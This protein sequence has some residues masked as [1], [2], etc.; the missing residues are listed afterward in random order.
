MGNWRW[1]CDEVVGRTE[2]PVIERRRC[3]RCRI[4]RPLE[5]FIRA[6]DGKAMGECIQCRQQ[7]PDFG[8]RKCAGVPPMGNR[9]RYE[10]STKTSNYR[11]EECWKK[12]R[13]GEDECYDDEDMGCGVVLVRSGLNP[14]LRGE[15]S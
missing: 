10:C 4:L 9:K 15:R 11:C 6:K 7:V 5:S 12:I 8:L 14:H 13:G 1:E 3:N 2:K